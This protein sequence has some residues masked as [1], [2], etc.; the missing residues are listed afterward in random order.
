MAYLTCPDD[1]HP[2]LIDLGLPSGTKWACCNVG[3]SAPEQYGN[4]YAW[5]EIQPKA[6]YNWDTYQ[7]YN[8]N[9]G[10]VNIGSDIG[11][12]PNYDAATANWGAPWRMPSIAQMQE[13]LDY[14]TSTW[15][16]QNGVYGRVFIGP[17][18]GGVFFPAAGLR[19]D[20]ERD[21]GIFGYYWSSTPSDEDKACDL[22]IHTTFAN[23]D[24]INPRYGGR[25]VRPV[26]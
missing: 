5:G 14:T 8:D 3:A 13:L 7:Y 9:T 20:S 22:N 12:N 11:G 25:S 6:V 16:T 17:N 15:T 10:I 1:H 24:G 19:F 26:R 4:Y 23:L 18:G 21:V 2:H